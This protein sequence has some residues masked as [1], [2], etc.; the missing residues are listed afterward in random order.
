VAAEKNS[1]LVLP[2]P[3]ELLRFLEHAP[4]APSANGRGS[5]QR[6]DLDARRVDEASEPPPQLP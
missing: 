4:G 1:T 3:V 5:T 2:F 6:T